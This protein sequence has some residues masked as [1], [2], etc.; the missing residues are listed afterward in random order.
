MENKILFFSTIINKKL[1]HNFISGVIQFL[2]NKNSYKILNIN[3]L[4]KIFVNIK[5]HIQLF[6]QNMIIKYSIIM[7]SN[8]NLKFATL[9]LKI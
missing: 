2:K 6:H 5:K 7:P 9:R 3:Y 8:N 1:Q 4:F